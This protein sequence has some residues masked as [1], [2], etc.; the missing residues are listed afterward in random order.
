MTSTTTSTTSGRAWLGGAHKPTPQQHSTLASQKSTS[1][2]STTTTSAGGV[3]AVEN[4]NSLAAAETTTKSS[5]AA[6]MSIFDANSAAKP[7][8]HK[9]PQAPF[10]KTKSASSVTVEP[11]SHALIPNI[12][13]SAVGSPSVTP[14]NSCRA[15]DPKWKSQMM[16]F[17]FSEL[18]AEFYAQLFADEDVQPSQL[19]DFTDEFLAKI[20]IT[21][22]GHRLRLLSQRK[23]RTLDGNLV[24]F[25]E[26]MEEMSH[27]QSLVEQFSER[28]QQL[29]AR[30]NN[31]DNTNNNHNA[32][33]T[34]TNE[35]EPVAPALV[36][37]EQEEQPTIVKARTE[38][39]APPPKPSWI[40]SGVTLTPAAT[41]SSSDPSSPPATDASPLSPR[42]QQQLLQPMIVTNETDDAGVK[43]SELQNPLKERTLIEL[44]LQHHCITLSVM[45]AASPNE[46]DS[47]ASSL[48]NVFETQRSLTTL[49]LAS[50][51]REVKVA[52]TE[53]T[54]FRANTVHS[55]ILS[56]HARIV[57]HIYLR[58]T[59]GVYVNLMIAESI[60]LEVD[61]A[62]LK[63][64]ESLPENQKNLQEMTRKF[65]QGL[66]RSIDLVP[67][68]F[69]D[70]CHQLKEKVSS[71]FPDVNPLVSVGSFFFL[72]YACPAVINP[73]SFGLCSVTP[74]PICQRGLLLV[75]KILQNLSNGTKFNEPYMQFMNEYLQ[76]L[77]PSIT[78]FCEQLASLPTGES[79]DNAG[80]FKLPLEQVEQ[81]VSTI[82]KIA[83]E[84]FEKISASLV[85]DNMSNLKDLVAEVM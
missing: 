72:R 4:S 13:L 44:L 39:S 81:S 17:G 14:N 38:A 69:R 52:S 12:P 59:L 18:D 53:K 64:T 21:K 48:V 56:A 47:L 36:V 78:N 82:Y 25:D 22:G 33:T 76:T 77:Q 16:S 55:K 65:V 19:N 23:T 68:A 34:N 26:V 60:P 50:I 63:P 28:I 6:L 54:L 74:S 42:T 61:P 45:E 15:F 84:N 73:T 29:E 30:I 66:Q 10:Q 46:M 11:S 43:I 31:D 57:G 49:L 75:A 51:D 20:G 27:L 3:P 1:T 40:S 79:R 85:K 70:I 24:S 58:Q 5:V 32:N 37:A 62:R 7:S 41:K 8:N 83:H 67:L 9:Q 80:H 2:N 71:K 35:S